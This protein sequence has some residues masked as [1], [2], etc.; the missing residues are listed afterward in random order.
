MRTIFTI[1]SFLSCISIHAQF[2]GSYA[3]AKWNL[4][5]SPASNGTVTTTGAP[6]SIEIRG[7]NG[8]NAADVDTDYTITA[9]ASGTWSFNWSYHTNDSFNDASYDPAGIIINGVFTQISSDG[10]G[11]DQSGSFVAPFVTAG[12]TIG[13][14]IRA[15]DNIEGDA[16]FTITSFNP[17]GGILPVH[18][19]G[20]N[21]WATSTG[22]QL[23]WETGAEINTSHF[24]AE[25]SADGRQFTVIQNVTAAGAGR[26][27]IIDLNPHSPVTYYRIKG[28]DNDGSLTYSQIIPVRITIKGPVQIFAGTG[29]T[30]ILSAHAPA[31]S[32]E[33]LEIWDA[34]G[35]LLQKELIELD[36]GSNTKSLQLKQGTT[37]VIYVSFGGKTVTL[38]GPR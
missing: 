30:L 24:V 28:V 19:T 23:S 36:K 32:K 5:R 34:S 3:P 17:P 31:S 11:V 35:R 26:Y 27:S 1:L 15:T 13:F 14:R 38:M 4:T 22:V 7:S 6:A 25:R 21:A 16:T 18:F 20:F 10:G 29:N 9:I 12:T 33:W 2:S 37:G 8:I